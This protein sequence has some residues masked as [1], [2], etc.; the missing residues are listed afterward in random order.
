MEGNFSLSVSWNIGFERCS[1]LR[2][3]IWG[4]MDT[5]ESLKRE[6]GPVGWN[7]EEGSIDSFRILDFFVDDWFCSL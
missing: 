4:F 3:I 5:V 6:V 7:D 2:I 1:L